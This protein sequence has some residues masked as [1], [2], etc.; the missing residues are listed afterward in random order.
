MPA[1]SQDLPEDEDIPAIQAISFG[2]SG[3]SQRPASL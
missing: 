2:S 1:I 3:A